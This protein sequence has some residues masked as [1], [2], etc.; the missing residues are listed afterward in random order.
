MQVLAILDDL[1]TKRGMG[2]IFISHDL[3]LVASFCDRVIIMYAGQI[4]DTCRAA[5]LDQAKHPYTQGLLASL[6]RVERP[7]EQLSV[8]ERD[9]RWITQPGVDAFLD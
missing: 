4:V 9:Q 8:L 7:V 6:P 1:V 2:L 3:N 5:E